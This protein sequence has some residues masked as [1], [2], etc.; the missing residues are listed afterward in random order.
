MTTIASEKK[1]ADFRQNRKSL[2]RRILTVEKI[3]PHPPEK[4]FFQFC[5]T[6]ELDWIHGWDCDLVYTST[7]YAE[8]DCI[9]TT[10]ENNPLGPGLWVFTHYEPNQRLE[11][12][13]IIGTSLVIHF[14]I[15]LTDTGDGTCAGLW[16]ITATAL[17]D[18]GNEMVASLPDESIALK[19]AVD[20]LDYFLATGELMTT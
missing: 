10:S 14:R 9:F 11:L 6:R 20:G 5:P 18:T 15:K 13:R 16:H 2:K 12:V 7:G 1:A 17:D 8:N 4:V 19:R 3:F